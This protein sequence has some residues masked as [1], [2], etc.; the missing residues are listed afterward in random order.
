MWLLPST[1]RWSRSLQNFDGKHITHTLKEIRRTHTQ[2]ENSVHDLIISKNSCPKSGH[3]Q[4]WGRISQRTYT[5]SLPELLLNCRTGQNLST[6]KSNGRHRRREKPFH[7]NWVHFPMCMHG[8]RRPRKTS[9]L[10]GGAIDLNRV[11]PQPRGTSPLGP[12]P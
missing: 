8:G 5:N 4:G 9:F 1:Q 6:K 2:K 12:N 3:R 10:Y 11:Q 7:G